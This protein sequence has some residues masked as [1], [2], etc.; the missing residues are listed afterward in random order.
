MPPTT[1]TSTTLTLAELTEEERKTCQKTVR[2]NCMTFNDAKGR[3]YSIHIPLER[4]D[5]AL[6][7][8]IDS[9]WDELKKFDKWSTFFC[10]EPSP[11]TYAQ[12][13]NQ[14][15]KDHEIMVDK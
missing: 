9:N 12:A 13:D 11:Y 7:F 14:S 10:H 6:K 8:F 15:Y 1:E 3:E 4:Y 5:E 2:P